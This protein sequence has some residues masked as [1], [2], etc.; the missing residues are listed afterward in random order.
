ME[1]TRHDVEPTGDVSRERAA[2]MHSRTA[3]GA[4]ARSTTKASA[5]VT[6]T[7]RASASAV[8]LSLRHG[9]GSRSHR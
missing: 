9:S 7:P 2:P 6:R 1:Q 3:W 8:K 4:C 5:G